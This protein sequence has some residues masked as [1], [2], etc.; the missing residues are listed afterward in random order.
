MSQETIDIVE[1]IRIGNSLWEGR[2]LVAA[3]SDDEF[4]A[5]LR[6]LD[7]TPVIDRDFEFQFVGPLEASGDIGQPRRGIDG[8]IREWREW[9]LG[10]EDFRLEF[11]EP[12][13]LG[14]GRV[15]QRVSAKGRSKAGKVELESRSAGIYAFRNGKLVASHHYLHEAQA[16][17]AA[18]LGRPEA[19]NQ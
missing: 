8:L 16:V 17:E 7:G 6:A 3:F 14:D 19:S 4:L 12:V 5:Q 9:L 11:D 15:F 1:V 2:D 18:G 10:W 13:D